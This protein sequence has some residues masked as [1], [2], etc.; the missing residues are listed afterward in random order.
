MCARGAKS[1]P[2]VAPTAARLAQV[3]GLD[4]GQN[5]EADDGNYCQQPVNQSEF[6]ACVWR[7]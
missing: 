5:P 7:P 4:A 6:T 2:G 1:V 3:P